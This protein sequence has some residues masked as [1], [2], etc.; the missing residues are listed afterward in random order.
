MPRPLRLPNKAGY[1]VRQ[2]EEK[3]REA[4][5]LNQLAMDASRRGDNDK[6]AALSAQALAVNREIELLAY[7]AQNPDAA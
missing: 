3:S 4:A 6:A 5:R 1:Y 2:A 7:K